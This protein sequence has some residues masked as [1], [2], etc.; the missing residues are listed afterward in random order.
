MVKAIQADGQ[1]PDTTRN[2]IARGIVIVPEFP[3]GAVLAIAGVL[4][5]IVVA[6]RLM[7][8]NR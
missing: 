3:A 2:G 1:S 7:R 4:G 6:Q 8:R 5:A